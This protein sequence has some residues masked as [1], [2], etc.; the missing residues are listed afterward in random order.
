MR[1]TRRSIRPLTTR[2]YEVLDH[3]REGLANKQIARRLGISEKT[4]KAHLT[5]VFSAL[6]VSDRTQAALYAEG[7]RVGLLTANALMRIGR[8][9]RARYEGWTVG[10]PSLVSRAHSALGASGAGPLGPRIA[11]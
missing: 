11:G 1:R 5:R 10:C 3:V 7:H 9:A 8:E 2:E 6:G 4:V